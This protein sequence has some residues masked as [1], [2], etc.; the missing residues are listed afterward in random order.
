[1]TSALENSEQ[2]KSV[3]NTPID[4]KS[5]KKAKTP[6][7]EHKVK[8]PKTANA[9]TENVSAKKSPKKSDKKKDK[10]NSENSSK[11]PKSKPSQAVVTPAES[12]DSWATVSPTFPSTAQQ[13]AET[14]V[15]QFEEAFG[16][17]G[18]PVSPQTL[19]RSRS[20][21][22]TRRRQTV[23]GSSFNESDDERMPKTSPKRRSSIR[24]RD[25][26][27]VHATSV[28][29]DSSDRSPSIFDESQE[30]S[31]NDL[32]QGVEQEAKQQKA[33]GV[34]PSKKVLSS[35]T[36]VKFGSPENEQEKQ[37]A[38]RRKSRAST[39]PITPKSIF[40]ASAPPT[41]ASLHKS[42]LKRKINTLKAAES[43][44]RTS[45]PAA[46]KVV[47]S[48]HIQVTPIPIR[49]KG[50]SYKQFC[51]EEEKER[52]EEE[53]KALEKMSAEHAAKSAKKQAKQSPT[54][55]PKSS[56]KKATPK[57]KG[58]SPT[59]TSAKTVEL[60][61]PEDGSPEL[62]SGRRKSTSELASFKEAKSSFSQ[63]RSM[64][65]LAR[66]SSA[67][68]GRVSE[69][70]GSPAELIPYGGMR[71]STRLRCESPC[72]QHVL[73]DMLDVVEGEAALEAVPALN[74]DDESFGVESIEDVSASDA[75]YPQNMRES[76]K[77]VR[78][79]L[80]ELE[81]EAPVANNPTTPLTPDTQTLFEMAAA[82]T[83]TD[84][85]V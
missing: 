14:S 49:G 79:V 48:P 11:T 9:S 10:A 34:S 29:A 75:T 25:N 74:L 83:G 24:L 81:Q 33:V 60:K 5:I 7:S 36:R 39:K 22:S 85:F 77:E 18:S 32:W 40:G 78:K 64:P 2:V 20:T 80:D 67:K 30:Q 4:K 82:V 55:S 26:L 17:I 47:F 72:V 71:Q 35:P 31:L 21:S 41:V 66:V 43:E 65:R 63:H 69:I 28:Q 6:A 52:L 23:Y 56:P 44:S 13:K 68:T 51:E 42:V 16:P 12:D 62:D 3:Q 19:D 61:T 54:K 59:K 70:G 46:K 8:T 84:A 57:L 73:D 76:A 15:R 45:S 38:P 58:K 27:S 37:E 53:Q 50:K 1:M